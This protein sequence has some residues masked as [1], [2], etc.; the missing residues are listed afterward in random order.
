MLK[1]NLNLDFLH[2]SIFI[3][4]SKL[5]FVYYS[6]T[7]TNTQE[8]FLQGNTTKY[9]EDLGRNILELHMEQIQ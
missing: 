1:I 3:T 4:T 9:L 2:T 8:T 5:I 6:L 7:I